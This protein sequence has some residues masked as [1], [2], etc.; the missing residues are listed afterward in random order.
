MKARI[1][2]LLI[3]SSI[4]MQSC[5]KVP[6]A[7]NLQNLHTNAVRVN[8]Y[9]TQKKN[10][11][12][13]IML[14]LSIIA[15]IGFIMYFQ[16]SNYITETIPVNNQNFD[17]WLSSYNRKNNQSFIQYGNSLNPCLLVPKNNVN[18]YELEEKRIKEESEKQ[19]ILAEQRRKEQEERD[20]I[21]R[22]EANKQA[23]LEAFTKV[24]ENNYR[25]E[26]WINYL[27]NFSNGIHM[28]EVKLLAEEIALNEIKNGTENSIITYKK[29]FPNGKYLNLITSFEEEFAIWRKAMEYIDYSRLNYIE[30]SG[31]IN[32]VKFYDNLIG[33]QT[34]DSYVS[35]NDAIQNFIVKLNIWSEKAKINTKFSNLEKSAVSDFLSTYSS[36]SKD[37]LIVDSIRIEEGNKKIENAKKYVVG[38]NLCLDLSSISIDEYGKEIK[39]T[40][41][42]TLI[43]ISISEVNPEKTRMKI[44][45]NEIF[46]VTKNKKVDTYNFNKPKR[47]WSKG[48]QDWINPADW[49]LD[50]CK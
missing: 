42:K 22:D 45:V 17:K 26:Y 30:H 34:F 20:R 32:S 33:K 3:T 37:I 4:I 31:F 28:E 12:K 40:E 14:L 39:G 1:I 27:T 21:A 5:S 24:K 49:D 38:D 48:T 50:I 36:K 35:Q 44:M 7:S 15:P 13:P 23:D 8:P 43:R 2:L 6:M 19:R 29:Y 47:V 10:K 16:K 18:A 11:A 41:S 46:N 25:N 9:F